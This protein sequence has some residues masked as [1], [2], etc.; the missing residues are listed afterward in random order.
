MRSAV[1]DTNV[2]LVANGKANH[3]DD[4]DCIIACINVLN[5]IVKSCQ[6]IV[7]LD[8]GGRIMNEYMRNLHISGQPGIGDEFLRWVHERQACP[9]YVEQVQITPRNGDDDFEEFPDDPDLNGFHHSDRKFVAVS[10]ACQSNPIILNASDT[11]WWKY[12]E[13]LERYGCHIN[14]LCPNLMSSS[15]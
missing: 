1:V 3:I 4:E 5:K 13:P 2:P 7:V 11:G 14:F 10:L 9:Q 12:R 6:I 15:G 8:D